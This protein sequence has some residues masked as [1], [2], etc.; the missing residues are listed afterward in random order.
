MTVLLAVGVLFFVLAVLLFTFL[1]A[2]SREEGTMRERLQRMERDAETLR[3]QSEIIASGKT[4]DEV[5]DDL[6][7]GRF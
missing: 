5:S 1:I 7:A 3:K 6:D 4:K 2:L